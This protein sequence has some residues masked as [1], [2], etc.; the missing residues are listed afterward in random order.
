[1][2]K[3]RFLLFLL[4][5]TFLL[6]VGQPGF[7]K[8]AAAETPQVL[9]DLMAKFPHKAYWNHVGSAANNPDGVTDSPCPNHIGCSWVEGA[10]SCN[11]FCQAIQ[12]MGFA[13]KAAYEIVGTNPRGWEMSTT[14]EADKL[15]V[16][17]VI[18]YRGNRH[19]LCVTGVKGNVISFVDCNWYPLC[20][21]RWGSMDLD[22]MPS[23]SYVL[24]DP[25]NKLKNKNLDFFQSMVDDTTGYVSPSVSHDETWTTTAVMNLRRRTS[26]DSAVETQLPAGIR[27]VVTD[28]K[29]NNGYLWG[30]TTYGGHE[31]WV[32]LDYCTYAQGAV[33]APQFLWFCDVRPVNTSFTLYWSAVS[34]AE[35][36][37]VF[38]YDE[39]DAVVAKAKTTD[40]NTPFT[41]NKVGA[42][43]AEVESY[44]KHAPSWILTGEAMNFKVQKPEDIRITEL[45]A[46][47]SEKVLTSGDADKFAVT[48]RPY[49]AY[50]GT[51]GYTSSDPKVVTADANGNLRAVSCGKATVTA[52]DSRTGVS[53]SCPV[54][55]APG[56]AQNLRQS[57]KA[58]AEHSVTMVWS[59]VPQATGY[60]V[61]RRKADGN[62]HY[63]ARVTTTSFTEKGLSDSK[64]FTYLVKAF[65]D[66]K[67]GTVTGMGSAAVTAVTKPAAVQKL[68]VTP[69]KG[70]L[71]LK[72][73]ANER[74][75][76][77]LIYR[78]DSSGKYEKIAE[79]TSN[80]LTLYVKAGKT[81]S[82]KVRAVKEFGG[83]RIASALSSAASGKAT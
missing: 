9:I 38:L 55:V 65:C 74:A 81:Y 8:A 10:C 54:S 20:Q 79:A 34:G 52:K 16:G 6:S 64:E 57:T 24:H 42:Y 67:S 73:A 45:Q 46:D 44:S 5:F 25:K 75:D 41:L 68:T 7:V 13:F 30:K 37:K 78:A 80:R 83:K 59:K 18:R 21:I 40:T 17:D 11:S 23:F 3:K 47:T 29:I 63:I 14:L 19:S 77:Y 35:Y 48:V 71:L 31:G 76:S 43:Y 27:F 61:Y 15:R 33:N 72:W 39:N 70:A 82:F 58:L 28:K 32:A 36:Y 2:K 66:T 12:C 22:D 62:F 56:R 49:C 51:I 50:K 4:C 53:V 1:M 60:Y 26:T 69:G